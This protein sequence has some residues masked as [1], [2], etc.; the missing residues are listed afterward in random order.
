MDQPRLAKQK[1]AKVESA[2][3]LVDRASADPK[4]KK[5]LKPKPKG[6]GVGRA[7]AKVAKKPVHGDGEES[8]PAGDDQ[9]D[10]AGEEEASPPE[11][12]LSPPST[13]IKTLWNQKD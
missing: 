7:K 3:A 2:Q 1:A 10:G 8:Q 11:P 4:V 5:Q 12:S 9:V 13:D 6:K